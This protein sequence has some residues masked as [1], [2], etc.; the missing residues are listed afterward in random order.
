M[1]EIF[2][3]T[4]VSGSVLVASVIEPVAIVVDIPQWVDYVDIPITDPPQ[5]ITV[6]DD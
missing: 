1:N 5:R 6:L 3:F 4:I 2:E